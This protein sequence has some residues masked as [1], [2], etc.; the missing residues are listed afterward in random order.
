MLWAMF[1]W[2]TLGPAIHVDVTLTRP[3]Y[4]SIVADYFT[5]FHGNPFLG[6]CGLFQ[7]DNV[8]CHKAKWFRNG[9]RS[10]A[11]GLRC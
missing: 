7:Q 4:L 9:L 1:Y 6:G 2:E 8:P 3:T 10:T 11:T 5:P